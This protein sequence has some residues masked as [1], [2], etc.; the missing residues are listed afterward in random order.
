MQTQRMKEYRGSVLPTFVKKPE[1]FGKRELR[2]KKCPH[3]TDL[4]A[5]LWCIFLIDD[6]CAGDQLT[7]GGATPGLVVLGATGKQTQQTM[8]SKP[9][10]RDA[11]WP[12]PVAASRLLP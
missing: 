10:S 8:K 11:P 1:L 12:A 9:V 4:W 3:Q 7:V 5:S 2:L 6:N